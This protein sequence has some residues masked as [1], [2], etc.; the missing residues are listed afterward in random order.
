MILCFHSVHARLQGTIWS[1][2]QDVVNEAHR[3]V[4]VEEREHLEALRVLGILAE[5]HRGVRQVMANEHAKICWDG[6]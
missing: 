6:G 3:E 5:G 1:T 2:W 4:S